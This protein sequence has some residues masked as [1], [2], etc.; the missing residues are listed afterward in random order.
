MKKE[1]RKKHIYDLRDLDTGRLQTILQQE[2]F[3]SDDDNLDEG[4]VMH[5][6][7]VLEEREPVFKD[8][9]VNASLEKF[10][11][12]VIP[13]LE[14][15]L[16]TDTGH[17]TG[18]T[19]DSEAS[20]GRYERLR[21]A[22][23][24]V[25]V[26]VT[27]IIGI[28]AIA[29]AAGFDLWEYVVSWGKETFRIGTGM[30][31]TDELEL[32]QSVGAEAAIQAIGAG[33]YDTMDEAMEALDIT[34]LTPIWIPD[35]FSLSKVETSHTPMHKDITAL[36]Q[37]DGEAL[38]YSV[39]AYSSNEASSA[40]EMNDGSGEV[41]V[42]NELEHFFMS[43]AE[44]VRVVWNMDKYVYSINGDVSKEEIIKMLNSI[45]EGAR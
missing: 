29:S 23:I 7:D 11:T 14:K 22:I 5:I 38:M 40:Y 12:Q 6:V 44:Q 19:D 3:L 33:S 24:L 17:Q 15:D 13:M 27:L 42:I 28:N 10:N 20:G 32:A 16:S 36:Y 4:L 2:S 37:K 25:A 1:K 30:E 21:T 35:G 34:V 9:D 41:L 18:K 39:T 45:Y 43:N 31:I 26:I 8:L